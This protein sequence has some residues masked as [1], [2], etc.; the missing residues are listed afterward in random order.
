MSEATYQQQFPEAWEK[1]E[2]MCQKTKDVKQPK[3]QD[4]ELRQS[5]QSLKVRLA[6]NIQLHVINGTVSL[7]H[8]PMG[9]ADP[10]AQ[11]GGP[12][13]LRDFE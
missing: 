1:G 3:G 11:M 5:D 10:G 2:R 4:K 8:A 7:E 13:L 9:W 6:S 12:N